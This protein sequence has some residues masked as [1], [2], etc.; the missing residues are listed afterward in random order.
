MSQIGTGAIHDKIFF[1]KNSYR[2]VDWEWIMYTSE[3]NDTDR[4]STHLL[5]DEERAP[6]LSEHVF[7]YICFSRIISYNLTD[8]FFYHFWW[9]ERPPPYNNTILNYDL[10]KTNYKVFCF[11]KTNLNDRSIMKI[12]IQL[13]NQTSIISM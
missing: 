2:C 9:Y 11:W 12:F 1:S 5:H 6:V 10:E 8:H 7:Y 13:E 4:R 3:K